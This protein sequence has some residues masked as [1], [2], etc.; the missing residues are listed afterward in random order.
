[1]EVKETE[2]RKERRKNGRKTSTSQAKKKAMR[3]AGSLIWILTKRH[4]YRHGTFSRII[5]SLAF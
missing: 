1:V 5:K 2:R 3:K 4:L